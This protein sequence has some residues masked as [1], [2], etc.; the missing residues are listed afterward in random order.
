[1]SDVKTTVRTLRVFEVFADAKHPL[2]LSELA[3]KIQVPPS[4]CL[5]IIRTLLSQGYLFEEGRSLYYPTGRMREICN[6]IGEQDFVAMRLSADLERLRDETSETVTLAKRQGTNL[7]YLRVAESSQP[8]RATVR[9]GRIRPLHA[10]AT[11][12]AL[13][14]LLNAE[15]AEA[16]LMQV[17]LEKITRSTITSPSKLAR[18]IQTSSELGWFFGFGESYPDLAAV[19]VP[20]LIDNAAYAVTIM[21]P[22]QRIEPNAAK[23]AERLLPL[24]GKYSSRSLPASAKTTKSRARKGTTTKARKAAPA[25]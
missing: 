15:E 10:T 13:L 17:P 24:V 25:T 12:K 2:T 20:L 3:S 18:E 5:L 7:I 16:L 9:V 19:S 21:G 4:S 6:A 8:V 23:L 14:S 11:G 22:S 1:M